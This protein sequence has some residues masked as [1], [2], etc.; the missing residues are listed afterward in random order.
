MNWQII[1]G[2][3]LLI[4]GIGNMVDNI[5][6]FILCTPIGIVFLCFGF[7][8]NG[9][10]KTVSKT[11]SRTL[12]DEIFH[13]AGV[14]YY[15]ENIK[16]LSNVNPDWKLS[17]KKVVEIGKSEK[18]IFHYN[19]VNRPVKLQPEPE[20]EHDKNA[21]AV[22]I[23]GELVGYISRADNIHVNDILQNREI[24]SV[25]G[26]IGGGEYKIVG[27]EGTVSKDESD[28]GVSIRIKYV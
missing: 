8:K 13:V 1:V 6:T 3:I 22:F 10:I 27:S 12:K 15:E 23:A 4:G 14:C 5:G 17:P 11:E 7:R 28:V 19:Y 20:N 18:R 16:K 21:I 25:S 9:I 24:K 2:V 26:F